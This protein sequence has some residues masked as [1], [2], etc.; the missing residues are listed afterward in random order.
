MRGSANEYSFLVFTIISWKDMNKII[1]LY[2]PL[3]FLLRCELCIWNLIKFYSRIHFIHGVL[4]RIKLCAQQNNIF[5]NSSAIY[6]VT[7]TFL[8][9]QINAWILLFWSHLQIIQKSKNRS[10]YKVNF[11]YMY[12]YIHLG[13]TFQLKPKYSSIGNISMFEKIS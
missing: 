10:L 7:R 6:L 2:K 13:F 4:S 3:P 8:W 1:K 5:G 11:L 9:Y 12:S